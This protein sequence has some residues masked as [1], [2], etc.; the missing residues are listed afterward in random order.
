MMA[1]ARLAGL[2]SFTLWEA[3]VKLT[4]GLQLIVRLQPCRAP[5]WVGGGVANVPGALTLLVKQ[6][7][8]LLGQQAHTNSD[9][10]REG[11]NYITALHCPRDFL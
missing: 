4:M 11:E 8:A 3:S 7:G 1:V 6:E 2:Q 9:R 5:I 10:D